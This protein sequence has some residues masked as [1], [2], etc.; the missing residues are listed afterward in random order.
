MTDIETN[1][2]ARSVVVTHAD[3][4]SPSE[5]L[6]KLMKVRSCVFLVDLYDLVSIR[7]I[8]I[9]LII[10]IYH[11]L[12]LLQPSGLKQSANWW[13]WPDRRFSLRGS[14]YLLVQSGVCVCVFL[15]SGYF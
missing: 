14:A 9:K 13:H 3:G 10:T 2:A 5:M 11:H 4:V 6:D 15:S 7:F 1:V 8:R 12:L